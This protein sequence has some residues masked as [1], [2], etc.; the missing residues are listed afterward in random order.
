MKF[1]T[2][3]ILSHGV[4]VGKIHIMDKTEDYDSD[5]SNDYVKLD[6]A[7]K[8][9]LDEIEEM[10]L[11]SPELS[12]YLM[13]QEYMISDPELKKRIV[14]LLDEGIPVFKAVP[15]VMKEFIK[16]LMRIDNDMV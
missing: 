16:G 14:L 15:A 4:V 3:S 10:K 11:K 12:S 2:E 5:S 8:R 7:I 13:V 9:S 6:N 1:Q